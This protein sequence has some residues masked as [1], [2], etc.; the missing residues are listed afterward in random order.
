LGG[1]IFSPTMARMRWGLFIWA[2][3]TLFTATVVVGGLLHANVLEKRVT[4]LPHAECAEVRTALEDGIPIEPGFRQLEYEFPDN[5][6]G[7]KGRLCRLHAV[8]SGAHIEGAQIRSLAD[9]HAF[10]KASLEQAGWRETKETKRF[11]DRSQSGKDVFA[12]F[13]NNAICVATTLISLVPGYIPTTD[14]KTDGQV[15][16]GSLFPYEREWWIAVDCFHL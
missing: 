10:L 3:S 16:L 12:L 8:G 4:A 2:L 5:E 6:H 13:K 9:M 15:Y 1:P 14:V 7:I 11:V